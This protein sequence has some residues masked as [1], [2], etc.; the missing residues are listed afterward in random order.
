MEREKCNIRAEGIK[1]C[2]GSGNTRIEVLHGIDWTIKPGRLTFLVGPSGCGKTTLISILAGILRATEGSVFLFGQELAGMSHRQQAQLRR[3]EIGF[4]F[5]QFHL[6]PALTARENAAI[7]LLINRQDRSSALQVAGKMLGKL[8]LARYVDALPSILSGGQQ[9]RVA[10][11]RAL[12]H[13]PRLLI[14][15]EPTA[16]LDAISGWQVMELLKRHAQKADRC[17]II[18]THHE[19]IFSF[20]DTLIR[21]EDGKITSIQTEED[22]R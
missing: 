13:E 9:Q 3:R 2:F 6:L 5:Q 22:A 10:I 21:M 20:A 11:A 15:D 12:V 16:S 14:C 18:V 8:G 4:I 17:V 19:Q 7:P 1:K